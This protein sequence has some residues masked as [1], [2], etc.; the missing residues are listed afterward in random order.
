[1]ADRIESVFHHKEKIPLILTLGQLCRETK[2]TF[3]LS[4][5]DQEL[6][7]R[8]ED[9]V[10]KRNLAVHEIVKVSETYSVSWRDRLEICEDTA[11]LGRE[12][13]NEINNWSKRSISRADR[14][15][16]KQ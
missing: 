10:N 11:I 15:K 2:K 7:T 16:P 12:L 14:E 8:V 4:V 1:M 3:H 5:N 6:F 9:W 13:A